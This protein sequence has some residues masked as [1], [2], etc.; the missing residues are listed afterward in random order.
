MRA[1]CAKGKGKEF[2]VLP[3][4]QRAQA[5]R[6]LRTTLAREFPAPRERNGTKSGH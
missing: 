1:A 4:K 3:G 2:D 5:R 6:D